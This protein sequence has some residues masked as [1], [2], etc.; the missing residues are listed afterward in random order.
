MKLQTG[1]EYWVQQRNAVLER[2]EGSTA[3]CR[4]RWDNVFEC[5]SAEL[6]EKSAPPAPPKA[7][8]VKDKV[9]KKKARCK[10]VQAILSNKL[11][12]FD[13]LREETYPCLGDFPDNP[14]TYAIVR[15]K[16]AGSFDEVLVPIHC[17]IFLKD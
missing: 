16:G 2:L 14:Q 3:V 9:V 1:K 12:T 17:V 8:K 5:D 11:E 6:Q 4:D 10:Q 13:L 15:V 7:K